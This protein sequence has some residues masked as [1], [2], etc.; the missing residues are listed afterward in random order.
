MFLYLLDQSSAMAPVTVELCDGH[1]LGSWCV[2]WLSAMASDR[3]HCT[4]AATRF[5]RP[6]AV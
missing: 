5:C 2:A 3:R 4:G 6:G 1:R